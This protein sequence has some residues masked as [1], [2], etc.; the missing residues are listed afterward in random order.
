MPT[1][2]AHQEEPRRWYAVPSNPPNASLGCHSLLGFK[3][4]APIPQPQEWILLGSTVQ[5][6]CT[7][8]TASAWCSHWSGIPMIPCAMH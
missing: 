8:G 2:T 6:T 3:L 4:R 7:P 5:E 1:P